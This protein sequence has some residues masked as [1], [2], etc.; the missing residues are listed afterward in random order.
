MIRDWILSPKM[1]KMA[2]TFVSLSLLKRCFTISFLWGLYQGHKGTLGT[3]TVV[4]MILLQIYLYIK[5]CLIYTSKCWVILCL[6]YV[7]NAQLHHLLVSTVWS[8]VLPFLMLRV[9]CKLL[10]RDRH[11]VSEMFEHLLPLNRTTTKWKT[12]RKHFTSSR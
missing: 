3:G 9:T 12:S 10:S 8:A 11:G 5:T 4:V 6:T 2:R 7:N 1:R